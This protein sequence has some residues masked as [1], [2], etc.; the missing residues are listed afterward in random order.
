MNVR[1]KNI[2]SVPA[3]NEIKG[4][5]CRSVQ[6]NSRRICVSRGIELPVERKTR[7]V[8]PVAQTGEVAGG[9]HQVKD[10]AL[11]YLVD[12]ARDIRK[13]LTLGKCKYVADST[14]AADR[15]GWARNTI[16]VERVARGGTKERE[17]ATASSGRQD[18]SSVSLAN[19]VYDPFV[20]E[21]EEP[22]VLPKAWP[23]FTKVVM[24]PFTATSPRR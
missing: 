9:G 2:L 18:R 14:S 24:P 1:P 15:T 21:K 3:I 17:C 11:H 5:L 23:A 6:I 7:C 16:C 13:T 20:R 19:R 12:G 22:L 10:A 4:I 8:D